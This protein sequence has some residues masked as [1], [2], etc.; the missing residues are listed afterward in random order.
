MLTIMLHAGTR[1]HGR[2]QT[3]DA[4]RQNQTPRTAPPGE[5]S[6]ARAPER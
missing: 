3:P 6:Q 5:R 1:A 4:R 2:V